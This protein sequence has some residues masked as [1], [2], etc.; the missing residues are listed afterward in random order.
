MIELRSFLGQ[1]EG[2]RVILVTSSGIFNGE[3]QSS[4]TTIVELG[5]VIQ[6]MSVGGAGIKSLTIALDKIIAWGVFS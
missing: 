6:G 5:T 2:K 4:A 3:V 1:N